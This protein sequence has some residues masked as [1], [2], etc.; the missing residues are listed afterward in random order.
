MQNI[1]P[2]MRIVGEEFAK[3]IINKQNLGQFEEKNVRFS[4]YLKPRLR[5]PSHN[6][7]QD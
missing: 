5:L 2:Q 1:K 4:E 7:Q 6:Y 3:R